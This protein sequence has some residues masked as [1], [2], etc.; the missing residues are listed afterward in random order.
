MQHQGCKWLKWI[1]FIVIL[2]LAAASRR[3]VAA[4][5]DSRQLLDHRT[6]VYKKGEVVQMF[7]NHVGPY[8]NPR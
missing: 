1:T 2:S 3:V 7:A 6:H 8:H 5:G 4:A